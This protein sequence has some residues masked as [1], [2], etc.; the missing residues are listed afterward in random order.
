MPTSVHTDI[1]EVVSMRQ[2]AELGLWLQWIADADGARPLCHPLH[3]LFALV[4][5]NEDPA[6]DHARRTARGEDA[7]CAPLA[8]PVV[9][10]GQRK[11]LKVVGFFRGNAASSVKL[12]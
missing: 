9:P 12:R 2:R 10:Q 7:G 1:E 11:L 8:G 3:R 5:M 4:T 6:P